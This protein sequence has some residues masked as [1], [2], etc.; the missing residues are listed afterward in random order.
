MA[1][2]RRLFADDYSSTGQRAWLEGVRGTSPAYWRDDYRGQLR[3]DSLVSAALVIPDSHIFDGLYFL[4]TGPQELAADLGRAGLREQDVPAIEV[5]GREETME[6]SLAALLRRD[7]RETLN[8]FVFKSLAVDVRHPLAAELARTPVADLDSWLNRA[9]DVP[10]AVAGL[11]RTVLHRLDPAVDADSLI[12]PLELGWRRWMAP[13]AG[14]RVVKWPIYRDFTVV[15]QIDEEGSIERNLRT[16]Q[17]ITAFDAVMA[18]INAGSEHRADISLITSQARDQAADDLAVLDDLTLVVAW[19]SR[20]RYRALASMHDCTCA[21]VDRPWLPA[22][23]TAH[24]LMREALRLDDPTEVPLPDDVLTALGDLQPGQFEALVYDVRRELGRWWEVAD[25]NALKVIADELAR[26]A[27]ERTR[28]GLG[29]IEALPAA[30]TAV[31]AAVGTLGGP[32]GGLIGTGG[33]LAL[34]RR[35]SEPERIRL[36]II[37][38]ALDRAS[39]RR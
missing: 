15:L 10:G 23:G 21:L 36:R 11:L 26:F 24:A 4:S 39:G 13:V 16:Q 28:G 25:V 18:T 32:V 30:G 17:G 20:L 9:D 5:R 1:Y 35:R 2:R 27:R 33:K 8:G 12:E 37:E 34:T 14:I 6:A 19:Y 29:I 31:G 38:S 7:G 3:F 22:V